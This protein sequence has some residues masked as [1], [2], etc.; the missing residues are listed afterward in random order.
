MIKNRKNTTNVVST[1]R[2]YLSGKQNKTNRRSLHESVDA[3]KDRNEY[4]EAIIAELINCN[5]E[6]DRIDTLVEALDNASDEQLEIIAY[7]SNESMADND[8]DND[9]DDDYDSQEYYEDFP[10]GS[11]E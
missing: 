11:G 1:W 7:D 4:F 9:T 10:T 5:W 8:A 2:D 3:A 6:Q